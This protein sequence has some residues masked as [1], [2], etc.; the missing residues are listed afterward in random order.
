LTSR[1]EKFRALLRMDVK[2]KRDDFRTERT[3]KRQVSGQGIQSIVTAIG[4]RRLS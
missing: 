4:I 2:K 3:L 1:H